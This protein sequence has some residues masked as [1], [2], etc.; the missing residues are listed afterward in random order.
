M[1]KQLQHFILIFTVFALCLTA[2]NAQIKRPNPS[3]QSVAAKFEGV[4]AGVE[5]DASAGG[6]MEAYTYTYYFRPDGTYA[7]KLNQPDWKTRV[8]GTYTLSGNTLTL[9]GK[10]GKLNTMEIRNSRKIKDGGL[11]LAKFDFMNTIPATR[12]ETV[13]GSSAG[14]TGS[15]MPSVGVFS[16]RH[17]VFDGRGNFSNDNRT[18][19]A[20]IGGGI[21]GG[22]TNNNKGSGTYTIKDS[23]LTLKY[24]DGTTLTKSFFYASKKPDQEEAA[25]INGNY[26]FEQKDGDGR[27][28]PAAQIEKEKQTLPL[29]AAAPAAMKILKAAN[30]A[31]GGTRLDALKTLKITGKLTSANGA[32]NHDVVIVYDFAEEKVRNELLQNGLS[33]SVEQLDGAKSFAWT[34]NGKN[35]L[36]AARTA[37]MR[38]NLFTGIFGLRS[39]VL[40][41]IEVVSI[42]I[43]KAKESK[44]IEV[45]INGKKYGW[46][47]DRENRLIGEVSIGGNGQQLDVSDDFRTVN[48]ILFSFS[49]ISQFSGLVVDFKVASIEVNPNLTEKDWAVPR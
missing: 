34:K 26:Y 40:K 27:A 36:P 49:N 38:Q 25:L 1:K 20:V 30:L 46:L 16:N 4:Y 13:S 10:S 33:V 42:K 35:A 29:E 9:I 5:L 14:G 6:G 41:S 24:A 31:H 7:A 11:T 22:G 15:G 48:G 21:G 2:A 17:F 43:D 45:L 19:V 32:V 44:A 18:A 23:V 39:N 37:E 28:T 3:K 8:D 47:I 12:L